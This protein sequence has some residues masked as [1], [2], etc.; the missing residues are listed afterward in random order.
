VSIEPIKIIADIIQTYMRLENGQVMLAY[1]KFKIP[2]EGLFVVITAVSDVE[3][4]RDSYI[5]DAQDGGQNEV[6]DIAMLHEI[7]IDI[8]SFDD[9]ARKRRM[10]VIASLASIYSQQKQVANTIQ[11]ARN[12]MPMTDT[13]SLEVTQYLSRYTTRVR[14]AAFHRIVNGTKEYYDDFTQAVPPSVTVNA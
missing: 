14:V 8:M 2:T 1:Q 7:Q 5:E 3:I 6:V 13:S 11:I 4:A 9:Q 12:V 10:E